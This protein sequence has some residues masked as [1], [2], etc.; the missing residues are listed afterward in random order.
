[1]GNDLLQLSTRGMNAAATLTDIFNK[2]S[3]GEITAGD[4]VTD[5]GESTV[6]AIQELT[7][8]LQITE[9]ELRDMVSKSKI[10]FDIFAE[11]MNAAFGDKAQEADK[12]V[13]GAFAN[14]KAALARI[15][16][17]FVAPLIEKEGP[18]VQFLNTAKARVNDFKKVMTQW[19]DEAGNVHNTLAPANAFVHMVTTSLERMTDR[20]K[21]LDFQKMLRPMYNV[22]FGMQ[23]VVR[24]VLDVAKMAKRA[25]RDIF[26]DASLGKLLTAITERFYKFSQSLKITWERGEKFRRVFRGLWAIVDIGKTALQAFLKVFGPDISKA[27]GNTAGKVL[28][29][30]AGIGDV[31]VG[32]RN[33][34]KESNVFERV[35]T[36]LHTLFS[37]VVSI[38][39]TVG[40]IIQK[41]FTFITDKVRIFVKAASEGVW[42]GIKAVFNSITGDVDSMWTNIKT[43]MADG[44]DWLSSHGPFKAVKNAVEAVKEYFADSTVFNFILD[45]FKKL[46]SGI[47][48]IIDS[49]REIKMDGATSFMESF[50]SKF[51]WLGAIVDFFKAAGRLIWKY[52]K[53]AWEV[54]KAIGKGIADAFEPTIRAFTDGINTMVENS[55]L[56]DVGLLVAGGAIGDMIYQFAR[57]IKRIGQIFENAAGVVAGVKS[58]FFKLGR[59]LESAKWLVYAESLKMFAKAILILAAALFIL[60]LIPTEQL[61]KGTTA[62]IVLIEALKRVLTSFGSIGQVA[63]EEGSK[64]PIV[65]L[66]KNLGTSAASMGVQMIMLAGAVAVLTAA[67]GILGNMEYETLMKGIVMVG[68]IMKMLSTSVV[69]MGKNASQG[70]KAAAVLMAMAIAINMLML[71]M[72]LLGVILN[73]G[74]KGGVDAGAVT[75]GASMMIALMSVITLLIMGISAASEKVDIKGAAG[76]A[77][78]LTTL[79]LVVLSVVASL[80]LLIAAMSGLEVN[81]KHVKFSHG[82]DD[83]IMDVFL[84]VGGLIAGL[85]AFT[86]AIGM[87]TDQ[88]DAKEMLMMAGVVVAIGLALK[89]ILSAILPIAV[90]STL[91]IPGLVGLLVIMHS[92]KKLIGAVVELSKMKN[93]KG[94]IGVLLSLAAAIAVISYCIVQIASLSFSGAVQGLITVAAAVAGL[95]YV[96][97][98][99]ATNGSISTG[100]YE[101]TGIFV[102]FGVAAVLFAGAIW[103]IIDAFNKLDAETDSAAEKIRLKIEAICHAIT[104][105]A[106]DIALAVGAVVGSIVLAIADALA[107]TWIAVIKTALKLLEE[108]L[109]ALIERIP[110]LAPKIAEVVTMLLDELDKHAWKMIDAAIST[111]ITIINAVA[112]TLRNNST[113]IVM[114]IDNVLDAVWEIVLK[115]L[116]KFFGVAKSKWDDWLKYLKWIAKRATVIIGGIWAAGKLKGLAVSIS[117]MKAFAGN[118]AAGISLIKELKGQG[119]QTFTAIGQVLDV[120]GNTKL[121]KMFGWVQKLANSFGGNG[122]FVTAIAAGAIKASLE[123]KRYV[124]A[125]DTVDAGTRAVADAQKEIAQAAADAY[126]EA[127]RE[128]DTFKES[129]K[130]V[131]VQ[132]DDKIN[133]EEYLDKFKDVFNSNGTVKAG[134]EDMARDLI[135]EINSQLGS[136]YSLV[137][138]TLTLEGKSLTSYEQMY[139]TLQNITKELEYKNLLEAYTPK[140]QEAEKQL[141]ELPSKI[142]EAT[143]EYNDAKAELNDVRNDNARMAKAGSYDFVSIY[144]QFLEDAKASGYGDEAVEIADENFERWFNDLESIYKKYGAEL[145]TYDDEYLSAQDIIGTYKFSRDPDAEPYGKY[146]DMYQKGYLRRSFEDII[147]GSD[148]AKKAAGEMEASM[149]KDF[150]AAESSLSGYMDSFDEYSKVQTNYYKAQEA[151][152]KG[153]LDL[154]NEYITRLRYNMGDLNNMTEEQLSKERSTIDK[155]LS[156]MKDMHEKNENAITLN[157]AQNYKDRLLIVD[158]YQKQLLGENSAA[159]KELAKQTEDSV[160][161]LDTIIEKSG[162][163][164]SKEV[165]KLP[166]SVMKKLGRV[167][168]WSAIANMDSSYLKNMFKLSDKEV[169]QVKSYA[170]SIGSAL[171]EGTSDGISNGMPDL[172]NEVDNMTNSV[173][174]TSKTGFKINSPSKVFMEIGSGVVEGFVK[175]INDSMSLATFATASLANATLNSFNAAMATQGRPTLSPIVDLSGIQN[176]SDTISTMINGK[177][178]TAAN[179]T[180]MLST[181]IAASI[182]SEQLDAGIDKIV[183][184]VRQLNEN[185]VT[186]GNRV[187]KLQVVMDT[188]AVVGQLAAP[189]DSALGGLAMYKRRGI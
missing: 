18:L 75:I 103:I 138:N 85:I 72:I 16:E 4:A 50:K 39:K 185:V 17:A 152:A 87:M 180:G 118:L 181:Q 22:M 23:K 168:D 177:K 59:T 5:M 30:S 42:N 44:W 10:S 81:T 76:M 130:D 19:T 45:A 79:S 144:E 7:G 145:E 137:N 115:A 49:F 140:L 129:L 172:E 120:N 34:I 187:N 107:E 142:A 83:A 13:T 67:I 77:L 26:P 20:L 61:V 155:E 63:A 182:S 154:A 21:N 41:T 149:D 90:L 58:M 88:F 162:G 163:T 121:A 146:Y 69:A 141:S 73:R 132:E 131:T 117:S 62:I 110:T 176:G 179:L 143:D 32:I 89:L 6:A 174:N 36:K 68:I 97:Q 71:P 157:I 135:P 56:G 46:K 104:G 93:P 15:G 127:T 175:G 82:S 160:S 167:S 166:A 139:D 94:A 40:S 106:D 183:E 25:F 27:I 37:F 165:E 105:S 184:T 2:V 171:P 9:T 96:A 116:L 33:W 80:A 52:G 148:A 60:A 86:F 109:D 95:L 1:M 57:S 12:T 126:A 173:I 55:D 8:G 159:Y 101:L 102:G 11:S 189:M 134:M 29:F 156:A 99:V 136:K 153:D 151:H 122:L 38:L 35:F 74:F 70:L 113:R 65:N 3:S 119:V 92:L 164:A 51:S 128:C 123:F 98:L 48:S 112:N 78:I 47:Q 31:L 124:D 186:L 53:E 169:G 170:E 24:S 125:L 54:I 161:W 91:A 66:L 150:A 147:S 158:K 178:V 111:A 64:N 28:D 108:T 133:T 84:V 43:K 188:G 14:V 100:L 114:A